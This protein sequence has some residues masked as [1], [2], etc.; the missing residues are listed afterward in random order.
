MPKRRR[1]AKSG[2]RNS[3]EREQAQ[4]G[5]NMIRAGDRR[6]DTDIAAS[7]VRSGTPDTQFANEKRRILSG[8]RTLIAAT[9]DSPSE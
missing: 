1:G 4:K 5:F 3:W 2:L 9:E 6:P 8:I 7:L